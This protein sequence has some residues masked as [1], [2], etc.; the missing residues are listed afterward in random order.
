MLPSPH[1]CVLSQISGV[2]GV[3][4]ASAE[5]S[6]L[7]WK[8]SVSVAAMATV[9][10]GLADEVEF[11]AGVGVFGRERAASAAALGRGAGEDDGTAPEYRAD[12]GAAPHGPQPAPA[13][14]QATA[15]RAVTA[16][17]GTARTR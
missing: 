5:D 1:H 11:A 12:H 7:A 4:V 8:R 14:K 15:S 6:A 13:I 16:S 10:P 9:L 17:T 3:V 2:A